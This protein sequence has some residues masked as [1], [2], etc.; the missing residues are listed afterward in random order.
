[1]IDKELTH[2]GIKGMHWGVRRFQNSDG[3]LTE[4]GK[5]RYTKSKVNR[6]II[7][8]KNIETGKKYALRAL[9]VLGATAV[10]YL[11]VKNVMNPKN[12]L[13]NVDDLIQQSLN[14]IA[15]TDKDG[16]PV[17]PSILRELG[18]I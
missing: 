2:Y 15:Y 8:K 16:N 9:G 17:D 1:M 18:L 4:A 11:V 7:N 10:T 6:L 14:N 3:T 13:D 12:V 5:K